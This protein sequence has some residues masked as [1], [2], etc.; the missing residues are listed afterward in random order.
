VVTRYETRVC[1][2]IPYTRLA[3]PATVQPLTI[4]RDWPRKGVQVAANTVDGVLSITA[5]RVIDAH[6]TENACVAALCRFETELIATGLL[7]KSGSPRSIVVSAVE[8]TD[9]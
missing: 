3:S 2:V 5:K 9:G 7:P 1:A 4:G 8:D 6:T